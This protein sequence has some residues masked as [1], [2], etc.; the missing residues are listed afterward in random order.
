MGEFPYGS[1]RENSE[2]QSLE[3]LSFSPPRLDFFSFFLF[4]VSCNRLWAGSFFLI[5]RQAGRHKQRQKRKSDHDSISQEK[6]T[7]ENGATPSRRSI[8]D[9]VTNIFLFFSQ[10][11]FL[12]KTGPFPFSI[13]VHLPFFSFCKF[14]TPEPHPIS[15]VHFSGFL[16]WMVGR[17]ASRFSFHL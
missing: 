17:I 7:P 5:E 2:T 14:Q 4:S 10:D 16:P 11:V 13:V 1:A 9:R 8:S 3:L 12:F 15:Q 6:I